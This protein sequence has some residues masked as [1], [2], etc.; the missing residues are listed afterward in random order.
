MR[1]SFWQPRYAHRKLLYE[2]AR[3]IISHVAGFIQV[4]CEWGE[5]ERA[6]EKP[7]PEMPQPLT[8]FELNKP[9]ISTSG[10]SRQIVEMQ[11]VWVSTGVNWKVW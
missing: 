7:V 3:E 9:I 2:D 4:L 5:K 1:L 10:Q 11:K 6:K 8:G